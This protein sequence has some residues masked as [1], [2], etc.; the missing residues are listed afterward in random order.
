MGTYFRALI[1]KA[2]ILSCWLPPPLWTWETTQHHQRKCGAVIGEKRVNSEPGNLGLVLA[3]A[4]PSS[5]LGKVTVL[6]LFFFFP[7]R[8]PRDTGLHW[9]FATERG[10]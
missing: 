10:L 5:D 6:F 1:Q 2:G 8:I 7:S 3:L 4:N 9:P